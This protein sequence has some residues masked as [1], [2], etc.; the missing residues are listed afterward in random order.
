MTEKEI[1]EI[2]RRFRTNKCNISHIRGCFVNEAKEIISE[3]DQS[4][5]MMPEDDADAMLKI[6]K[7][8]LS[9]TPGR[10]LLDIEFSTQQVMESEEHKLLCELR[11]TQLKDE[12]LVHKLY[13]KIIST[14]ESNEGYLILLAYDAY[15]VFTKTADGEDELESSKVFNYFLCSVCPAKEGKAALSYYLPGK[16]FRTVVADTVLG[17]PELG[18]M[19]PAFDDRNANIYGALYYTKKLNDSH[20]ATVDALFSS[21]LPMPALTQKETFAQILEETAGEDC[22]MMVVRTV[23][24]H[25]NNM[26]EEHKAEKIEEPPVLTKEDIGEMLTYSGVSEEKVEKFYEKY[27]ENFGK[28][29]RLNPKNI[30]DA[31]TISVKTAEAKIKI[32]AGNAGV[33]E[34]RIIDGVKYILI[35]ADADVEVNGVNIHI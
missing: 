16:C 2:R 24:S 33:I 21:E 7:K 18:F 17:A 9:G 31:K 27:D 10:Q 15:D 4:L 34:T 29:A 5:G 8:T 1:A 13:E 3:F 25:I 32:S 6:L 26:L 12:E 30:A 14:Y 19:F 20:E 28:D 11:S 22:N 35:R 23:H